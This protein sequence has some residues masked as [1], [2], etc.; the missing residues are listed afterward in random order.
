MNMRDITKDLGATSLDCHELST[1]LLNFF[2]CSATTSK[3]E[4]AFSKPDAPSFLKIIFS[5]NHL[6]QSVLCS[7]KLSTDDFNQIKHRIH[8]DLLDQSKIKFG[9]EIVFSVFKVNGYFQFENKIQ[10]LPVPHDAPKDTFL[11]GAHPFLLEFEYVSS[12]NYFIDSFRRAQK[13]NRISTI[14][15]LCLE[16]GIKQHRQRVEGHW[17]LAHNTETGKREYQNLP[18]G[19]GYEGFKPVDTRFS[20]VNTFIPITAIPDQ[21]Y[22][23]RW[24]LLNTKPMEIPASLGNLIS[25]I[26]QLPISKREQFFR[27]AYWHKQAYNLYLTS[28]SSA[29]LAAVMAIETMVD[30]DDSAAKCPSCHRA[31]ENGPTKKFRDFLEQYAPFTSGSNDE[32]K[33]KKQLYDLRSK[34][35]HGV[36]IFLED[37]DNH[38]VTMNSTQSTDEHNKMELI[39]RFTRIALV[40]WLENQSM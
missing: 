7:P 17:V 32:H 22:F 14:L 15:A 28:K 40:N 34:L 1:L 24:K 12:G 4:I 25:K 2:E 30:T 23:S 11:G 29:Y 26:W 38:S 5:K 33:I 3:S 35:A 16:G 39:F 19:Y 18:A 13:A 36:Q 6:L 37:T 9:R 27:A 10:I 31:L 21:E 20:P 8:E